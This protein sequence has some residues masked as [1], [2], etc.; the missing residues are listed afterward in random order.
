MKTIFSSE[1]RGETSRKGFDLVNVEG[2]GSDLLALESF[3]EGSF[4]DEAATG[5]ARRCG[6]P[7]CRD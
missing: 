1:R 2:G 5:A 4:I 7:F 3:A 6:F